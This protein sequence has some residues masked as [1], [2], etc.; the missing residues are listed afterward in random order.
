[1]KLRSGQ[2]SKDKETTLLFAEGGNKGIRD[3]KNKV[4]NEPRKPE[5]KGKQKKPGGRER[6]TKARSVQGGETREKKLTLQT[7]Y[8]TFQ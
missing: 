6:G 5:R 3:E 4:K 7:F 1:V 8:P 2:P